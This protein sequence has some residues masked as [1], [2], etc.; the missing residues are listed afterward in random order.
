MLRQSLEDHVVTISR[1]Q[2][3]VTL[4]RQRH[5]AGHLESL[6][7]RYLRNEWH[8]PTERA[9]RGAQ[10]YHGAQLWQLFRPL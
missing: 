3:T 8:E 6:L 7:L 10:H 4:S 5:A 1:A 2:G 9:D